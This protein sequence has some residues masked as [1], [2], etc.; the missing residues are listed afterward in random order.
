[1][2]TGGALGCDGAFRLQ[3]WHRSLRFVM[4]GV[5]P[6]QKTVESAIE[7]IDVTPWWAACRMWRISSR[8]A[9]GMIIRLP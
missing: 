6:G 1:M 8:R 4:A 3:S 9:G 7:S 2:G 5:I